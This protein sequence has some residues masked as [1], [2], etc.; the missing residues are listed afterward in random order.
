MGKGR[1]ARQYLALN[2]PHRRHPSL[3]D[4]VHNYHD[5]KTRMLAT[6]TDTDRW[7]ASVNTT[8]VSMVK[9]ARSVDE[10]YIAAD[11]KLGEN[12]EFHKVLGWRQSWT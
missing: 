2:S 3:S 12:K 6:M 10:N 1:G 11:N 9:V 7:K 4:G 5:Y 8:W